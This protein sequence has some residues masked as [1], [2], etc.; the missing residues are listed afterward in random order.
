MKPCSGCKIEKGSVEFHKRSRNRDGLSCYC[1]SC[2]SERN[3]AYHFAHREKK[4]ALSANWYR[5]N[6]S[7]NKNSRLLKRYGI[8]LE[9]YN[10]MSSSQNGVCAICQEAETSK[11][12]SGKIRDLAVDHCHSTGKVRGLLCNRCNHGIG[13]LR[14]SIDVLLD[15]AAYIQKHK[16]T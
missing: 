15:A 5:E 3:S 9:Q 7:K 2:T 12:K 8:T 4:I 16:K 1:K 14:D 11:D 6:P 13:K 10:Q